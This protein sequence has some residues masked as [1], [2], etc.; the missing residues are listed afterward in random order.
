MQRHTSARQPPKR[1]NMQL[2]PITAKPPARTTTIFEGIDSNA[3]TAL[4]R[5]EAWGE[6][7]DKADVER[8]IDRLGLDGSGM[9]EQAP[10]FIPFGMNAAS[11]SPNPNSNI[12]N[13]DS[14]LPKSN[15]VPTVPT[16]INASNCNQPPRRS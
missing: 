16:P 9:G 4:F 15:A 13:A 10:D 3:L 1:V 7:L 12:F 6:S 2:P 11:R 14:H 5:S 8:V